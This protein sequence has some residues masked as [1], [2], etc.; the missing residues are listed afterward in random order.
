MIVMKQFVTKARTE[1]TKL[2]LHL[3]CRH[4]AE[5]SVGLLSVETFIDISPVRRGEGGFSKILQEWLPSFL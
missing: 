5:C 3:E 2:L 4:S 1:V